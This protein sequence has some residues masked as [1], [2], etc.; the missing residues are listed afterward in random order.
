MVS[1]KVKKTNSTRDST[2]AS[3]NYGFSA[4]SATMVASDLFVNWE[5]TPFLKRPLGPSISNPA[6]QLC[7]KED[8]NTNFIFL[9]HSIAGCYRNPQLTHD[10]RYADDRF[11][12]LAFRQV[13]GHNH[14]IARID[15]Q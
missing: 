13:Q 8:L 2:E 12:S 11:E 5:S 6:I 14:R 15:M 7:R 9:E 4:G 1:Q 3:S 10:L